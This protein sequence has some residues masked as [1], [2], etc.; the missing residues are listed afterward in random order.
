MHSLGRNE[1]CEWCTLVQS[2]A[3]H[4]V[5]FSVSVCVCVSSCR[6]ARRSIHLGRGECP[7][8]IAC[9]MH[10]LTAHHQ[11]AAA[12]GISTHTHSLDVCMMGLVCDGVCMRQHTHIHT[13]HYYY[14]LSMRTHSCG[15]GAR[16]AGRTYDSERQCVADI[17]CGAHSGADDA[18]AVHI[19]RRSIQYS[20]A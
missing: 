12:V 9:K 7:C 2:T 13:V 5:L 19:A 17:H 18:A 3:E 14:C 10:G 8:T 11:A 1:P 4:R 6:A 20:A 15:L 16:C